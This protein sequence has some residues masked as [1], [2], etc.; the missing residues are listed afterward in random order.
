MKIRTARFGEME[1]KDDDIITFPDGI[2]GFPNHHRYC[3]IDSGDDTLILWLQSV[4]DSNVAFPVLE[5]K[6]FKND[7]I[8]KLSQQELM[9]LKLENINKSAVFSI[10]TIPKD[11]ALMTANLKA[12]IVINLN[13]QIGKQV[14]LQ[15][16]EYSL[17][18]AMFKEL[19]THLATIASTRAQQQ[20]GVEARDHAS[21]AV[22]LKVLNPTTSIKLL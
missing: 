9:Q 6:V 20:A 16:N 12:P 5:P 13:D 11:V 18:H 8:V 3:L 7:Y 14:I 22:S 1:I 21:G 19:K 15:E 10:L 2:L 17:K 4:D